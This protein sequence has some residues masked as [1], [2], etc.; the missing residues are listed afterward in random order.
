M[1][2]AEEVDFDELEH[3]LQSGQ[4]RSRQEFWVLA[5]VRKSQRPIVLGSLFPEGR[6]ALDSLPNV[7]PEDAR[8][9]AS[10][11]TE[12]DVVSIHRDHAL[13]QSQASIARERGIGRST[14]VN[15][16]NGHTWPHLHPTYQPEAS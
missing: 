11:L 14:V 9:K 16:I 8:A 3:A 1:R 13:G 5:N 12:Q 4:L 6:A 7:D 15:I 10:K 2:M